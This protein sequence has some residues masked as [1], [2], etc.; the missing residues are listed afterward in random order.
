MPCSKAP[1]TYDEQLVILKARGLAIPNES[2][3]QHCLTHHNYYRL[4]AYRLPFTAPGNTDQFQPGATFEQLWAIYDFDRRL[5]YL[6]SEALKRLEISV[7]AR[8]AYVLGHAY[9]AQAFEDPAVFR[10]AQRHQDSLSKLDEELSR[11]REPFIAHYRSKYGQSRPPIW[12][13]CEVMSFGLLSR[14]YENSGTFAD[15]KAIAGT[16]SLQPDTLKSLLEHASYIRN[17]CAHHSQVWSR[18]FTVK[19]TL[20][21]TLPQKIDASFHHAERQ[22]IYNTLILL[23]H[24]SAVIEPKNDWAARLVSH[25]RTLEPNLLPHMGFPS[26]WR[27]RP[28]W[29]QLLL[30]P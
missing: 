14:M 2:F 25:L 23:A 24:T 8:W 7:R 20:P 29:R 9:G 1:T 19:V 21:K 22:R 17:L 30:G 13:S 11:S 26:D 18:R 10:N 5:R 6:L 27:H 3:A 28:L 4:C 16:Y 12:A 15:Q